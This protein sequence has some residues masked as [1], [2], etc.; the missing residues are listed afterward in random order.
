LQYII[1][2]ATCLPTS[3]FEVKRNLL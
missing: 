2:A 1:F 3:G